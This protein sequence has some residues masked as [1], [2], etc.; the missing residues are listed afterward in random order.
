MIRE[1]SEDKARIPELKREQVKKYIIE[2][3]EMGLLD[4]EAIRPELRDAI[5]RYCP[6]SN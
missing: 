5:D 2:A 4:E 3:R 6:L 1:V